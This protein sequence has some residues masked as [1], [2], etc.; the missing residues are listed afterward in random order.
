ML[1]ASK[2]KQT[3]SKPSLQPALLDRLSLAFLG[4]GLVARLVQYAANRSLWFDEASLAINLVNR[5]YGELLKQLDH[6]QAAPPL[7]L[8]G[9]KLAIQLLGNHEYALRLL[10][11]LA[12]ILSLGLFY[13]LAKQLT[14][15]IT[16]PIAIALFACLE[17]TVYYAGEVKPYMSDLTIALW[18]FLLLMPLHCLY[19]SRKKRIWLSVVGA[20]CIWA[21]FPCIFVLAA[22]ELINLLKLRL[23]QRSRL[24][25]Q[26][27]LLA[28]LPMY[29]VWLTSF[30]VLY[31]LVIRQALDN[32]GLVASWAVRYPDSWFDVVWLLDALGQFFYRPLGF[33]GFT[34]A[35]AAVVFIC[36]CVY[37]YR[38]DRWQLA[39]L[40][41]PLLV[42]LIASYF[43]K[44]PFR[45]RLILFLAPFALLIVAEGL[46]VCMHQLT[47]QRR[48]RM[49]LSAVALIA[50]LVFP[51]GRMSLNIVKPERFLFDHVRPV[52]DYIQTNWQAGDRLYVL[53]GPLQQFLY[54]RQRYDFPPEATLLS[55]HP[56]PSN[57]RLTA[58]ELLSYRQD[59]AQFKDQPRVWLLMA[60]KRPQVE[61]ALLAELKQWGQPLDVVKQPLAVGLLLD[62]SQSHPFDSVSL[63]T[64]TPLANAGLS[65]ESGAA[66]P[67]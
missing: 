53:P 61:T 14:T 3:S 28:R 47:Q 20:V 23:W 8:W 57:R 59:L 19:L 17:Y 63:T 65:A 35:I 32:E 7:F 52:L 38:R 11:L 29:G 41:A 2:F 67:R 45:G 22:V 42:T 24:E 21:S 58:A 54:Y 37:L 6:G 1:T 60:R 49:A 66:K 26:T 36:G 48:Y 15:G 40:N 43:H 12:G 39:L 30:G 44:Y 46:T 9:E 10:P 25:L 18:L 50:L 31:T 16:T 56:V 62:L 51:V 5:S 33:L 64:A 55:P 4:F 13:H 34:D 27:W